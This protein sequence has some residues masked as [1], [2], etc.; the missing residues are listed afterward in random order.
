VKHDKE[1]TGEEDVFW[2]TFR[3]Q[4]TN[5]LEREFLNDLARKASILNESD[6]LY[7]TLFNSISHELRIPVATIMGASDALLSAD[8]DKQ[9]YIPLCNEIFTASERLNRL[10]ENLLNMSRLESGRI[11]PR[12]D[13][14]DVH[15]LVN[16]VTA[17]LRNELTNFNLETVIPEDM[18]LVRIDIGL[19]EQVLHNL[20]FN[21]TQYSPPGTTIRIKTYYDKPFFIMEV[22][23]RGPGFPKH[24]IPYVFNKFYRVE[25]TQTGGTGLGLSIVK[26]FVEAH[27][28]TV[29]IENR[30]NSGARIAIKIPSETPDLAMIQ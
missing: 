27:N 5:A 6:K 1:L 12:L 14:Y 13:W 17:D 9:S 30:K 21:S 15:D 24:T 22:M 26:G 7:R 18:P 11:T 10:I 2:D 28:G 23:D 4:V 3:V 25:G 8:F 19:M 16:K 20:V 29:T